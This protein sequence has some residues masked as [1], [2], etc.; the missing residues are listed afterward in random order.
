MSPSTF[1]SPPTTVEQHAASSGRV[2]I[3]KS[4]SLSTKK[5]H[6][7]Q[8]KTISDVFLRLFLMSSDR[9]SRRNSELCLFGFNHCEVSAQLCKTCDANLSKEHTEEQRG[10][11]KVWWET[12]N[13]D[14]D[15]HDA[16]ANTHP[17]KRDMFGHLWGETTA[18]SNRGCCCW[19]NAVKSDRVAL[20]VVAE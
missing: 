5:L 17:P 1:A 4:I 10:G 20:H 3:F 9:C 8:K 12:M 15:S 16:H 14:P 11:G 19:S 7:V 6:V 18:S 13:S 2:L